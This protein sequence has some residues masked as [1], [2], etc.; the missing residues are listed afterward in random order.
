MIALLLGVLLLSSVSAFNLECDVC[1]LGASK[2]RDLIKNNHTD[3]KIK[4]TA[5]DLCVDFKIEKKVVCSDLINIFA[6]QFIQIFSR[7]VFNP[8]DFC[9]FVG[10]CPW[11]SQ[12]IAPPQFPKPKPPYVPPKP[13]KPGD[14]YYYMLHLTD[15]HYDHLYTPGTNAFCGEPQCCRPGNGP[16]DAGYWGNYQCD[17]PYRYVQGLVNALKKEIAP[18]SP[19]NI[20]SIKYLI[21]GGDL[22]PHDVWLYTKEQVLTHNKV[23]TQLINET[24]I[25]LGATVLPFPGN[26]DSNPIN[27]FAAPGE[28]DWLY[29]SF[30]RD[31]AKWLTPTERSTLT[32]GGWYAKQLEPG[33]RLVVINN[34]YCYRC[35]FF[36]YEYRNITD[37]GNQFTWLIDQLQAAEDAGE[38]VYI[39]SHIPP[40]NWACMIHYAKTFE[41]IVDRYEN[42]IANQFYGHTHQDEFFV[43]YDVATRTRP[44]STGYISPSLTTYQNQNPAYRIY[45]VNARTKFVT[46]I[47]TFISDLPALNKLGKSGIPTW[48]Y[49]YDA[50][51]EYNLKDLSPSSWAKLIGQMEPNNSQLF[52]NFMVNRQAGHYSE[53]CTGRCQWDR[54]CNVKNSNYELVMTCMGKYPR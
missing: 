48:K 13:S 11:K 16:G 39:A 15:I 34:M 32:Y 38:K 23:T 43:Q 30:S 9:G 12:P 31:W 42:T 19:D 52:H 7:E 47:Y 40:Q 29:G 6:P 17:V 51:R 14:E 28:W 41:Y 44:I 2:I 45:Q 5:V 3:T 54:L 25:E 8:T 49:L 35:N 33:L 22:S 20:P 10:V 37:L 21:F 36:L 27:D 46:N 4:S 1:K 18:G 24:A 53:D 26:H 50:K